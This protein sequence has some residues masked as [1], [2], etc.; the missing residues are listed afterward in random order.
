MGVSCCVCPEGVG[1]FGMLDTFIIAG[2]AQAEAM[3]M[4][5]VG[6]G[7]Y[8]TRNKRTFLP[9]LMYHTYHLQ[10]QHKVRTLTGI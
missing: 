9:A 5:I 1:V 2:C 6:A 3:P 7:N 4:Y 8:N 10:L